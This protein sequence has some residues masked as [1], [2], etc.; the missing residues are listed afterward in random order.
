MVR[1]VQ[2][3]V[4]RS[5]GGPRRA[6]AKY[7]EN[8]RHVRDNQTE[9]DELE[10][11]S[12]SK[13]TARRAVDGQQTRPSPPTRSTRRG[14]ASCS[15][16]KPSCARTAPASWRSTRTSTAQR[17]QLVVAEAA[18]ARV[19]PPR[20][21]GAAPALG[22]GALREARPGS[23]ASKTRWT[24]TSWSTSRSSSGRTAARAHRRSQGAAAAGHHLGT[25]G[26]PGR[27]VRARVPEPDAA[28]RA[29]RRAL[30]RPAGSRHGGRR[31]EVSRRARDRGRR[32]RLRAAAR[33]VRVAP[34]ARIRSCADPRLPRSRATSA[35]AR[36]LG[37]PCCLFAVVCGGLLGEAFELLRIQVGGIAPPDWPLRGAL[38]CRLRRGGRRA[39]SR[40][41]ALALP[42]RR[43]ARWRR[44][45][46]SARSA[47]RCRG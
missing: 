32:G 19:R 46:C 5:P 4:G 22:G 33:P 3:H 16:S 42:A 47:D 11:R 23:A 34:R 18:G 45:R 26:E 25:G 38:C 41:R 12:S 17:R 27:R 31:E 28:L 36:C 1:Q 14:S 13:P 44:S 37:R 2:E 10:T 20:P 7:T 24:S 21:G 40:W 9:I 29:R 6:A 35:S 15:I 30:P 43:A 39:A 8:D